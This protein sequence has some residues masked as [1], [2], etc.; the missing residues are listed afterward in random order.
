MT[1]RAASPA[2]SAAL[3]ALRVDPDQAAA[4][5]AQHRA[6]EEALYLE[7]DRNADAILEG[8]AAEYWQRRAGRDVSVASSMS[9]ADL[10]RQVA[11]NELSEEINWLE[12]GTASDKPI[13]DYHAR[14]ALDHA[15]ALAYWRARVAAA[16]SAAVGSGP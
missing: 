15:E 1:A 10:R 11:L 5:A 4:L 3:P 6:T 13:R 7:A 16:E 12:F 8:K 2:R 14:L 9:L